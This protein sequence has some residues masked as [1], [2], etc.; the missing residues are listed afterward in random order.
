M[1]S[2]RFPGKVLKSINNRPMIEWQILR[3]RESHI[4]DI[5][6]A[7]SSESSDDELVRVV[8]D[9]GIEVFRGS[10]NDV[11]SRY[12]SIL[13]SHSPDY[14]IRLTGDCPVVM[15][16]L[17]DQMTS[18]FE[19]QHVEYL[20]NVN[21]P[22]F[23]DGLDIEIISTKSFLEFSKM[24]LTDKEKEHVT[25]GMRIRPAQFK[26][27]NFVAPYDLSKMR[28]TVDY[29]EDYVFISKIFKYFEGFEEQ[30][31]MDDILQ[32]LRS[33]KISHNSIP[34]TFRNISLSEREPE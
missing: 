4:K 34:H 23:P 27:G 10:V 26:I 25:F 31:K 15:P 28:W 19:S 13:E 33:G 12:V 30:F 3:I 21:P 18:A 5:V 1:G 14:F 8:G 29:E 24:E 17:L 2:T 9:L 11:H 7:T 6:L 20:S 32:A 22:T 16:D